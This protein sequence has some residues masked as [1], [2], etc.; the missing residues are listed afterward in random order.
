MLALTLMS[1]SVSFNGLAAEAFKI[2]AKECGVD[3]GKLQQRAKVMLEAEKK[4]KPPGKKEA[5]KAP[6]QN[7]V[8]PTRVS[9]D[10]AQEISTAGDKRHKEKSGGHDSPLMKTAR[11]GI[12]VGEPGPEW[13][14]LFDAEKKPGPGMLARG[15][16]GKS[17]NA[18]DYAAAA[19]QLGT[20]IA[21]RGLTLVYGGTHKGLM[22][23]VAD[24]A[25]AEFGRSVW[26]H[27]YHR[28][29]AHYSAGYAEASG[30]EV[31]AFVFGAVTSAYP[32][33]AVPYMLADEDMA[34][35][36]EDRRRLLGLHAECVRNDEWPAYGAGVQIIQRPAW[37]K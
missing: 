3:I 5:A 27:G 18:K 24:A 11:E 22:G 12:R 36:E 13:L 26:R 30:R 1:W 35:G 31:A 29:A 28:Q 4:G 6:S 23:V 37:V 32:F 33:L 21:Q 7:S 15:P 14:E 16:K 9:A 17:E 20:L 34:R 10:Q 19:A 2:V 8:D 25:P